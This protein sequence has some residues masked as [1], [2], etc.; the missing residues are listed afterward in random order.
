MPKSQKGIFDDPNLHLL[1][2]Q[3]D[4]E[5][6]RDQRRAKMRLQ[7][8]LSGIHKPL[9]LTGVQ[10][11]ERALMRCTGF[12]LYKD[13]LLHL[14]DKVYFPGFAPPPLGK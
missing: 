14:E 12:D 7:K 8:L 1:I 13:H 9:N 2:D 11:G 10:R 3:R 5:A 4:I 6:G